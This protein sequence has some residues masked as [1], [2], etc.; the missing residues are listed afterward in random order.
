MNDRNTLVYADGS[1]SRST[2]TGTLIRK[3]LELKMQLAKIKAQLDRVEQQ[4]KE[5][6]PAGHADVGKT[7]AGWMLISVHREP[8]QVLDP[9]KLG[10]YVATA[11]L[12]KCYTTKHRVRIYTRAVTAQYAKEHAA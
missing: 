5:K 4:I 3:R 11:T 7:D 1:R 12:A 8:F 6:V 9:V 10:R 2:R